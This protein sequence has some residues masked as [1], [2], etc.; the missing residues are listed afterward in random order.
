MSERSA[1]DPGVPTWVDL[2]SPDPA[3]SAR[4]YG[5]LFGWEAT[6]PGPVE[7]TGGYRMFTLNGKLVA[8]LGPLMSEGQPPAWSTYVATADADATAASVGEAGGSVMVAPTTVLESGR[9]AFFVDPAGAVFGVWQANQHHGAQLVNQPGA[10]TWN[11]LNAR[12]T[13]SPKAFYPRVF[14]W[15]PEDSEM[16]PI[17]YTTWNLD[18]NG[19]AGMLDL[20]PEVPAEVP[21]HWLVYF[22]VED[23]DAGVARVQELGG[24]VMRPGTD[25]PIGRFAIVSDPHGATF[26]VIALSEWPA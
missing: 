16:G 3:A 21:P 12:G 10:L 26:G 23:C 19:V 18:G 7:E 5:Q 17:K 20:P 1:Y 25:L 22:G 13:D 14:G 8:G 11:E 6:E 2:G 4:F 15:Q 9:M 24:S